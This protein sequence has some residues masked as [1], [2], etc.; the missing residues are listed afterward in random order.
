[1]P[2]TTPLHL[3]KRP[4]R[5]RNTERAVSPELVVSPEDPATKPPPPRGTAAGWMR[6]SPDSPSHRDRPCATGDRVS[7]GR[8]AI[9]KVLSPK[10]RSSATCHA[11]NDSLRIGLAA[12]TI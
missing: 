5:F 2:G 12:L 3:T 6:S 9:F 10:N 11:P 7:I 1:M 8:A 4:G